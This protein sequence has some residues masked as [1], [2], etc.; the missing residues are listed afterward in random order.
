MIFPEHR[1][2]HLHVPKTAGVSVERWLDD[3]PRNDRDCQRDRLFGWD[4][5]EG[6]YLQHA[7]AETVRR[8]AGEEAFYDHYR[9]AVVH[10]PFARL[11]SVYYYLIDQNR[12]LHGS[13]ERFVRH[14]PDL[15]REPHGRKGS[16]HLPQV[17]Y[18]RLDDR[19]ACDYLAYFERLPLALDPVKDHLGLR[20]PLGR[21]NAFHRPER[22][23][24]SVAEHFDAEGTAIVRDVYGE[25][26]ESYGY[27][28]DP[29]DLEP[30]AGIVG[31]WP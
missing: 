5:E 17:L 23:E 13:F 27:S 12:K 8:L 22:E 9:F 10:N 20:T 15:V 14:L 16:H 29:D 6:I 30:P 21:H 26:F 24:R 2:I 1:A 18:T 31:R 11:V 3:R 19:D 28:L 25:D 7:T 4:P